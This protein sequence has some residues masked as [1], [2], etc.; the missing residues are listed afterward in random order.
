MTTMS[1]IESIVVRYRYYRI[2]LGINTIELVSILLPS[3]IYTVRPVSFETVP[4]KSRLEV[5]LL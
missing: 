4:K 2:R 1:S 5:Q 3:L